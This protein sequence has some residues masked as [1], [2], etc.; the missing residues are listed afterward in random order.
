M[1]DE[2]VVRGEETDKALKDAEA[3][4]QT[5]EEDEEFMAGVDKAKENMKKEIEARAALEGGLRID[6]EDSHRQQLDDAFKEIQE[7]MKKR[8]SSRLNTEE[9]NSHLAMIMQGNRIAETFEIVDGQMTVKFQNLMD[10]EES[11]IRNISMVNGPEI[12]TGRAVVPMYNE[13]LRK[14]MFLAFSLLA[15]N[16]DP[17]KALTL[18]DMYESAEG[19]DKA[20]M[21]EKIS[22]VRKRAY[23][24]RKRLPAFITPTIFSALGIWVEYLT[25]LTSP[26]RVGNF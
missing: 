10:S 11:F 6:H 3:K 17:Y 19:E 14:E 15:I 24:L 25:D 13:D 20:T 7:D 8:F 4:K 5:N 21:Q 1:S 9:Q 16:D 22:E 2:D 23:D 18:D 26:K 12:R